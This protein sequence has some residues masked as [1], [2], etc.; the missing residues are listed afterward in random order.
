[1]W[2]GLYSKRLYGMACGDVILMAKLFFIFTHKLCCC[3]YT[4]SSFF[5]LS[6]FLSIS[7]WESIYFFPLACIFL[8]DN[9]LLHNAWMKEGE[10]G[11]ECI[12]CFCFSLLSL[13]LTIKLTF[14]LCFAS[15]CVF[16]P[17]RAVVIEK[18]VL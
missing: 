15:E 13:D 1:M 12:F 4:L 9:I 17:R 5:I 2:A 10:M 16:H 7:L 18:I 6:S 3:M 14:F 8:S 11:H